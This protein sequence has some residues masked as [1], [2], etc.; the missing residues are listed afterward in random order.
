MGFQDLPEDWPTRP[1]TDRA[2]VPDVLDLVVMMRDR[3]AGSLCL[4]LCDEDDRLVQ[5]V[6]ISDIDD[7]PTDDEMV[8]GIAAVVAVPGPGS[9]VL[10]ALARRD[11]LSITA[12]DRAW[13]RVVVRACET[14]QVRLLGMHVVTCEGSREMPAVAA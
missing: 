11:G 6:A 5:P 4:L 8:D 14:A 13:L 3:Y 12:G 10:A 1:L 7:C 2:L 9:S